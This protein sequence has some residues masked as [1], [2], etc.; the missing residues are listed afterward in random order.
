M[1]KTDIMIDFADVENISLIIRSAYRSAELFLQ[2]FDQNTWT[3]DFALY[4]CMKNL[5]KMIEEWSDEW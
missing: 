5:M 3:V 1:K 4:N 2:S